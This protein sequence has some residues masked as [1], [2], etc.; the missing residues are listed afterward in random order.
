MPRTEIVGFS[1]LFVPRA[2]EY[3]I[4]FRRRATESRRQYVKPGFT[5][6]LGGL[7]VGYYFS[8]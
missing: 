3:C 8:R 5:G 2:L 4:L 7:F 1:F 6:V